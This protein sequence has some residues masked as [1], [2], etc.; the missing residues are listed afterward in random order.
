MA[1]NANADTDDVF[2]YAHDQ[3]Y[4]YIRQSCGNDVAELLKFQSI[5]SASHLLLT[6][7]ND[8]LAV[9]EQ[10]SSELNELRQLCCFTVLEKKHE[11]KLGV[12]L[13][14]DSVI[15]TLST[16]QKEKKK[17]SR[18]RLDRTKPLPSAGSEETTSN[19]TNLAQD[20]ST[21]TSTPALPT[22]VSTSLSPPMISQNPMSIS[23]STVSASLDSEMLQEGS[24]AK[25]KVQSAFNKTDMLAKLTRQIANFWNKV[26]GSPDSLL[27][28]GKDYSVKIT[29]MTNQSPTCIVKCLCGSQ[30]KLP[31]VSNAVASFKLSAFYRHVR[32]KR[33]GRKTPVRSPLLTRNS[34]VTYLL[35]NYIAEKTKSFV[36]QQ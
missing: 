23:Q 19:N 33:C 27:E 36:R 29:S 34:S 11:V 25:P 3:F 15:R 26:N 28:E 21:F 16:K 32:E 18:N 12:K 17:E 24:Q 8:I 5:R 2:L 30:F 10:E 4:E 1:I 7:K 20:M 14:I 31:F 9:F 6:S 22:G 13:A 35:S